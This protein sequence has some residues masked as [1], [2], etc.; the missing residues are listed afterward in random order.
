M[1]RRRCDDSV[2]SMIAILEEELEKAME[3]EQD[4][5]VKER[6]MSR[7][8]KKAIEG[9]MAHEGMLDPHDATKV[10]GIGPKIGALLVN[11]MN[12]QAEGSSQPGPSRP[13]KTA[14]PKK[15]RKAMDSS[16]GDEA[17]VK[18]KGKG[19]APA[20]TRMPEPSSSDD[21]PASKRGRLEMTDEWRPDFGKPSCAILLGLWE[22]CTGTDQSMVLS[23]GA[24]LA[25][26]QQ[27]CVSELISRTADQL[28]TPTAAFNTLVSKQKLVKVDATP[29]YA[30]TAAGF[31][32][33]QTIVSSNPR[34]G[35]RQ[36]AVSKSLFYKKPAVAP[37]APAPKKAVPAPP[38]RSRAEV[39]DAQ[40]LQRLT[41]PPRAAVRRTSSS[42]GFVFL[43]EGA[44][45]S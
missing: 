34:S 2:E 6:Y 41:S 31:E 42:F 32:L 11:R 5:P 22:A 25:R 40:L 19:K 30:L 24:I 29:S 43:N 39:E 10:F 35:L 20:R 21:E 14:A 27:Y 37:V 12:K 36:I 13:K 26:A 17:P 23:E 28:V 16:S 9:L 38:K 3:K 8:Y 18:S 33:A 4:R 44:S 45:R 1:P 15:K 7:S